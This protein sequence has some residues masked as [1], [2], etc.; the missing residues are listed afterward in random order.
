MTSLQ[1]VIDPMVKTDDGVFLNGAS[2]RLPRIMFHSE[3]NL[4]N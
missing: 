3:R 1:L 2:L 4:R